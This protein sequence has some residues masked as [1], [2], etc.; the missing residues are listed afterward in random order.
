MQ[1]Y[2]KIF[3][4]FNKVF[5]LFYLNCVYKNVKTHKYSQS[6]GGNLTTAM[7]IT[8][9]CIFCLRLQNEEIFNSKLFV[10]HFFFSYVKYSKLCK[11]KWLVLKRARARKNSVTGRRRT[12][13]RRR[14][15]RRRRRNERHANDKKE[16]RSIV[17]RKYVRKISC[18]RFWGLWL[19]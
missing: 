12:R 14:R 13:S 1:K 4:E 11:W 15:R 19:N 16:E 9:I 8:L 10:V 7:D 18:P 5:H 6:I 17:F 3:S 2:L